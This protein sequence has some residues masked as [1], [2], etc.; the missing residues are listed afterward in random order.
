MELGQHSHYSDQAAGWAAAE[1][2]GFN[3][4][5]GQEGYLFS[6]MSR[7]GWGPLTLLL[8][9]TGVSFSAGKAPG[10]LCYLVTST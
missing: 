8:K 9:S 5:Q 10:V 2:S 4:R 1:E 6:K 7:L 3:S